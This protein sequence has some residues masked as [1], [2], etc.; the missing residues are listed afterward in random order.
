MTNPSPKPV[1]TIILHDHKLHHVSW[2]TFG[3]TQ[4]FLNTRISQDHRSPAFW[5]IWSCSTSNP[6]SPSISSRSDCQGA[7]GDRCS[8]FWRKAPSSISLKRGLN[9][10]A[11]FNRNQF[12]QN[13]VAFFRRSIWLTR[14]CGYHPNSD[15]YICIWELQLILR[16]LR[17]WTWVAWTLQPYTWVTSNNLG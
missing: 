16:V 9:L 12:I 5:R 17:N 2:T 8:F 13:L 14:N 15:D 3:T 1:I 7:S 10:T 11:G 4:I 6:I